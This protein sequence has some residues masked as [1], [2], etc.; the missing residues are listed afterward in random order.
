MKGN[1]LMRAMN[2]IDEKYLSESEGITKMNAKPKRSVFKVAVSIAAATLLAVPVGAYAY[3]KFTHRETVEQYVSNTELIEQQSPE[4]VKNIVTENKD[5]RITVDSVLSDGNIVMMVFTHEAITDKGLQIRDHMYGCP[6]ACITYADGSE[7][8]FEQNGFTGVPMTGQLAGYAI[9]N[10]SESPVYDKTVSVFSCRGID[11]SKDV[12][13]ELY[14]DERG[15]SGALE[16]F[17]NRN[18]PDYYRY[19]ELSNE[20]DGLEFT[21]NFAPNVKCVELHS[22]DGKKISMSSFDVYSDDPNVIINSSDDETAD[23]SEQFF[24]IT[25]DGEKKPLNE[26]NQWEM[27]TGIDY[28]YIIYGEFIDT[29]EYKGVEINGVEYMR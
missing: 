8:P 10:E 28:C 17:V 18:N 4:A 13:I 27:N 11:L 24:L 7:G 16:Y 3:S 26:T 9:S 5:Y 15:R 29:D 21:T 23:S 22:S 20:L 14:S 19:E 1:D 25:N 12:K 6:G 2:G